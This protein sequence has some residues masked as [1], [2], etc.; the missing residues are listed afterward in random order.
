MPNGSASS[1]AKSSWKRADTDRLF[2]KGPPAGFEPFAH[3]HATPQDSRRQKKNRRNRPLASRKISG[4]IID[5]HIGHR[6]LLIHM[7]VTAL[8]RV[9]PLFGNTAFTEFSAI[10]SAT[11]HRGGW[12][13]LGGATMGRNQM[14]GRKPARW[15]WRTI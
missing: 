2:Q 3:T 8:G 9:G 13:E 12:S 1:S 14:P 7:L 11:S 5:P 4:E 6:R 15:E 10:L